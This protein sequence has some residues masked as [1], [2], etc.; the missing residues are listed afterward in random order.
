MFDRSWKVCPFD[1][2]ECTMRHNF[3]DE[4]GRVALSLTTLTADARLLHRKNVDRCIH[5][6]ATTSIT[7][8]CGAGHA[9]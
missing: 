8:I 3:E 6:I 2:A 5:G 9:S 7:A 4:Q 1:I